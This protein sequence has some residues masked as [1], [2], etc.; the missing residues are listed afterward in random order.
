MVVITIAFVSAGARFGPVPQ[1]LFVSDV[2]EQ[3][4]A[5]LLRRPPLDVRE[6]EV[7]VNLS[8]DKIT[9]LR[10][11]SLFD[12]APFLRAAR[13]DAEQNLALYVHHGLVVYTCAY[14]EKS[15]NH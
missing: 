7:R 5:S 6:R 10:P 14:P 9:S 8:D 1:S 11:Y 12:W 3:L 15:I 2:I 4:A 13:S